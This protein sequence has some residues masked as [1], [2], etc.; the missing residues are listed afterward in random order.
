MPLA[1]KKAQLQA[2]YALASATVDQRLERLDPRE[3][4]DAP[5]TVQ[6]EPATNAVATDTTYIASRSF[7]TQHRPNHCVDNGADRVF[8]Y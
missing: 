8:V 3:T 4:N 6:A 2:E 7:I 1:L 5:A